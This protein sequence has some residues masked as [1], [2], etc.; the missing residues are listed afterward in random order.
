MVAPVLKS[1][2]A[3]VRPKA[4][5]ISQTQLPLLSHLAWPEEPSSLWRFGRHCWAPFPPDQAMDDE[6]LGFCVVFHGVPMSDPK[7]SP[8]PQM[9]PSLTQ[10]LL[11]II[12]VTLNKPAYLPGRF[13]IVGGLYS[14]TFLSLAFCSAVTI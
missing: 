12:S 5:G 8:S 4:H 6:K 3:E 14:V 10:A 2:Q 1:F 13:L 7:K 11:H 9:S